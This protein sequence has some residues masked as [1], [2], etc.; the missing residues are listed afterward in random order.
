M[1][2]IISRVGR[3][4]DGILANFSTDLAISMQIAIISATGHA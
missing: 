2:Y 3:V 1:T 4:V